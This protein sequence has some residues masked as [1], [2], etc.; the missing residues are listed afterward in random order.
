M[1][2]AMLSSNANAVPIDFLW[3]ELTKRCNLE[4]VHCYSESGPDAT[5]SDL[6]EADDYIRVMD[7]AFDLGCRQIQFIGGEPTL[8]KSLPDL[9]RHAH[10]RGFTFIEV[11][12]NLLHMPPALA[13]LIVQLNVNIATSI[14]GENPDVHAAVTK[15]KTSHRRT[16]GNMLQLKER[17]VNVRAGVIAM[18][19]NHGHVEETLEW[20]TKLGIPAGRDRLRHF[21]RG[22]ERG[23]RNI[24][25]LCGTCAGG[26]LRIGPDGS[27]SPCNMS[28]GWDVG[29]V[30]DQSLSDI[31]AKGKLHEIRQ[32]IHE[33]VVVPQTVITSCYPKQCGPYDSCCPTTQQ[34]YPCAP[35]NC[36]PCRPRG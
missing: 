15:N 9:I 3:M 22:T 14:Y 24:T 32:Q 8:N 18:D 30:L 31:L 7:Q 28:A 34:C 16:M 5:E 33:E 10:A 29:S 19:E 26:T 20:L 4:C 2:H 35:N 11:F 13:D 1:Q 25:E 36:S 21:G 17:G 12:T 27:V 6:M 23:E